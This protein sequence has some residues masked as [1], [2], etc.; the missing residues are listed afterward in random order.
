MVTR[1]TK[2]REQAEDR[3]AQEDDSFHRVLPARMTEACAG[4]SDAEKQ[5]LLSL[6]Q[7]LF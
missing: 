5:Q 6:L 3:T 4:F 2:P 1:I 7:R